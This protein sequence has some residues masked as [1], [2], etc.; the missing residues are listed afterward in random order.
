MHNALTPFVVRFL[1]RTSMA[2]HTW[3]VGLS[4]LAFLTAV[5]ASILPASCAHSCIVSFRFLVLDYHAR[6]RA[7]ASK[8]KSSKQGINT[9]RAFF[10]NLGHHC[11]HLKRELLTPPSAARFKNGSQL[12][13]NS[14]SC[15]FGALRS[16]PARVLFI[17]VGFEQSW[18]AAH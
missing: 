12:L 17:K 7:R 10:R 2:R 6:G 11:F 8:G 15:L 5:H 14:I 4:S 16:V 3:T 9:S 18:K 1:K 13:W